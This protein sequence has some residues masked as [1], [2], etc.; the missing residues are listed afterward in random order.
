MPK[1]FRVY[2]HAQSLSSVQPFATPWTVAHQAPL[3]MGFPGKNTGV[4][5]HSVL[6]GTF[7]TQGTNSYLL[8]LLHWQ[9]YSLLQSHLGNPPAQIFGVNTLSMVRALT[10]QLLDTT[11]RRD[12]RVSVTLWKAA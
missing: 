11:L 12:L 9:A 4:G 5:C 3:S 2:V 6:Q 8:C 10:F 7:P 1:Y